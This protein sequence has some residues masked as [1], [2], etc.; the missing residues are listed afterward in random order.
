V[1]AVE[2]KY[3]LQEQQKKSTAVCGLRN[4]LRAGPKIIRTNPITDEMKNLGNRK[5]FSQKVGIYLTFL[6][7]DRILDLIYFTIFMVPF[8]PSQE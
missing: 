8:R 7:F 4:K 5:T 1:L 2:I 6:Y 3:L